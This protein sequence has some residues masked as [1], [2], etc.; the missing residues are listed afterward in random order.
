MGKK[1]LSS[2]PAG[3]QT[4]TATVKINMEASQRV[5]TELSHNSAVPLGMCPEDS[6]PRHTVICTSTFI[7]AVFT[8]ARKWQHT[9]PSTDGGAMK[10]CCA[11]TTEY[12]SD[13]N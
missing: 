12:Y 4:S 7:A 5:K 8:V 1:S 13:V 10:T 3:V 9:W 11:H 6:R 2:L